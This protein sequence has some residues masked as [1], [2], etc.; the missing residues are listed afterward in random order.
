M[1]VGERLDR[2][3]EGT[4]FKSSL[5]QR[6]NCINTILFVDVYVIISP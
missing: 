1:A 4:R 3:C 6:S 2:P 5:L